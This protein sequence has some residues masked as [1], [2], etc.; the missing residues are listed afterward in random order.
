MSV[1]LCFY[2]LFYLYCRFLGNGFVGRVLVNG[3][4]RKGIICRYIN[5]CFL[6]SLVNNI[7]V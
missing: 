2:I 6:S 3:A 1:E 7:K 4:R 5:I